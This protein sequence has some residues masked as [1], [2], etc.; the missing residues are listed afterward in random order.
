MHGADNYTF[1]NL[2]SSFVTEATARAAQALLGTAHDGPRTGGRGRGQQVSDPH[3]PPTPRRG[4]LLLFPLLPT[5]RAAQ[6]SP[7]G[8]A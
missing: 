1:V 3:S 5:P 4:E 2:T 8:P 6:S 7:N